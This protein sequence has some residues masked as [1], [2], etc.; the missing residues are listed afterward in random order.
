MTDQ[1]PTFA[2]IPDATKRA[3][4]AVWHGIRAVGRGIRKS[5][6]TAVILVLIFV[7]AA[8][9][10]G[11]IELNHLKDPFVP[12]PYWDSAKYNSPRNPYQHY[13]AADRQI[14]AKDAAII[15]KYT[16]GDNK[17]S[18][19]SVRSALDRV[20][21]AIT[22]LH[23]GA[24]CPADNFLY[25]KDL[26]EYSRLRGLAR[27]GV[28]GAKY[29]ISKGTT[30]AGVSELLD[31]ATMGSDAGHGWEALSLLVGHALKAMTYRPLHEAVSSEKLSVPD[32][33]TIVDRLSRIDAKRQTPKQAALRT[34]ITDRASLV[35]AL[36]N[37]NA[38][39]KFDLV[40]PEL[41]SRLDGFSAD[42][43]WW[44][45]AKWWAED[46]CSNLYLSTPGVK[47]WTIRNYDRSYRMLTNDLGK[48][49]A[50]AA[51]FDPQQSLS[52]ADWINRIFVPEKSF[53][54]SLMKKDAQDKALNRGIMLMAAIEA[55]RL[56]HG[57]YPRSL[58]ALVDGKYISRVPTDPFTDGKPFIYRR[59]GKKYIV[60][61][62][63]PNMKDDGGS[64]DIT[65]YLLDERTKG[66]IVFAPGID[67]WK[68][69]R[70]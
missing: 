24:E 16:Y 35:D 67:I 55:Y 20:Q 31:V 27:I 54:T 59:S 51:A 23:T 48:P 22:E 46:L 66:D 18:M 25:P 2:K 6:K 1:F 33:K 5:W 32:Y 70:P 60:Y 26:P 69:R 43:S 8:N 3:G 37:K 40:S 11:Y 52:R 10:S 53:V 65:Y 29:K 34:Y 36:W 47:I 14:S 62:V 58:D 61:S 19:Q 56:E 15:S 57:Q 68:D 4:K 21:P 38:E 63:G 64:H 39:D 9:L 17:P 30:G 49:Y 13:M 42:I 12:K 50:Q 44:V 45:K 7:G 28:A 41:K